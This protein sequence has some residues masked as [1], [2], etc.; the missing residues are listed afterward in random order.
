MTTVLVVARSEETRTLVALSL[1]SRGVDALQLE[2]LVEV[3]H[4][5]QKTAVCGILLDLPTLVLTSHEDKLCA[6]EPCEFYPF[7][8]FKL[9]GNEIRLLSRTFD[10]FVSECLQFK[11]RTIRQ[12]A[13]RERVLA[14]FLS[15]SETLENA[16][17]VVTLNISASGCF[18]FSVR[19]W[20]LG[21]HV[22]LKF[23]GN[24]AVMGGTICTWH[25][26]GNNRILPGI[27]IKLDE[28]WDPAA[29]DLSTD[30]Q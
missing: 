3:P 29:L 6:Q 10:G 15:A 18:V 9:V 14:V 17:K 23:P 16:E 27:G 19:E 4:A 11:P 2:S 28:L 21:E 13:R 26:W 8:K 1:K 22:W 20:K 12:Y 7:A 25:P 5:L 24:S 30:H